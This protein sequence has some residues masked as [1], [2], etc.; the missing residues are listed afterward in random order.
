[1][2]KVLFVL[3]Y[4]G[5]DTQS[6]ETI[7]GEAELADDLFN[8]L[9]IANGVI[10]GGADGETKEEREAVLSISLG[11]LSEKEAT[12]SWICADTDLKKEMLFKIKELSKKEGVQCLLGIDYLI[13]CTILE[14]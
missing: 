12:D 8:K 11:F 4:I 14:N 6:C 3:E 1:M 2:K 13:S 7:I 10:F 5:F 9:K